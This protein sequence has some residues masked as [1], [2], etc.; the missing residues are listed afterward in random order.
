MRP[1]TE[2]AAPRDTPGPIARMLDNG[3]TLLIARIWLALPFLAGGLMKLIDWRGGEAE[4]LHFGLHPAWLFNLAS[5]VTQ[6]AASL[7][8]ILNRRVWL[9]AGALG[10]FTVT[11][12]LL[13]HRFWEFTGPERIGQQNSFLE[14]WA[15]CAGFVLVTVVA[16]RERPCG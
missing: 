16:L 9:A 2:Y 1:L 15:I 10:V 12:T 4:M 8:L 6:L 11:A 13:A 7:L 5:L 14:H 3:V